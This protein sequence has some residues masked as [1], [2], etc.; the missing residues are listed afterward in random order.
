LEE[1]N[2]PEPGKE[3]GSHRGQGWAGK[4]LENVDKPL[5]FPWN[6]RKMCDE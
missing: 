4:S 2:T 5:I 1:R 3:M 6:P